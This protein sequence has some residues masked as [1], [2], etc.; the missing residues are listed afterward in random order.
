MLYDLI[1]GWPAIYPFI[2]HVLSGQPILIQTAYFVSYLFPVYKSCHNLPPILSKLY[3][4]TDLV[5]T[6]VSLYLHIIRIK[7]QGIDS[8]N[9]MRCTCGKFVT[10]GLCTREISWD[11]ILNTQ[12]QS[13]KKAPMF[14]VNDMN[15]VETHNI[16][17]FEVEVEVLQSLHRSVTYFF[18]SKMMTVCQLY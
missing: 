8:L 17:L 6:V 2:K 9:Y 4:S 11:A 16:F 10:E 18:F 15:L 5:D 12:C 13:Q 3:V 7:L 1:V 14:D